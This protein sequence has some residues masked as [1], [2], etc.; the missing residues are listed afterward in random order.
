[1]I[2]GNKVDKVDKRKYRIFPLGHHR[3]QSMIRNEESSRAVTYKEGADLARK[4]QT[5]FIECSAKT[6]TGVKD[7]FEE[8]VRKVGIITVRGYM[9]RRTFDTNI[10]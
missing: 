3:S 5:L 4:L 2:V 8:L 7:V 6:N 10:T 1:M 9:S